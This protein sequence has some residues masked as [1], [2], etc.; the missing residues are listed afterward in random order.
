MK[1]LFET[2]QAKIACDYISDFHF[3]ETKRMAIECASRL[4][5]S[6]F[7]LS[8]WDDL[9]NYLFSEEKH[10]LTEKEV[11]DYFR[12]KTSHEKNVS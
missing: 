3:G 7:P 6:H 2:I 1:D 9:A 4:S 5:V 8:Q 11:T 10:F 12:D